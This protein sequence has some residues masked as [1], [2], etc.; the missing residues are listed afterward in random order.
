MTKKKPHRI[1]TV[2]NN[3]N[4]AES[5]EVAPATRPRTRIARDKTLPGMEHMRI[6]A[7]DDIC[8]SLAEIR[9]DKN[10][11]IADENG[12]KNT[13]HGLMRKFKKFTWRAHGVELAR[14][15]GEE[16]LRVRTTKQSATAKVEPADAGDADDQASIDNP[17][18]S[19]N[20]DD[21]AAEAEAAVRADEP[22]A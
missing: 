16:K 11:L 18:T 5:R 15:E 2:R 19:D 7:L 9:A 10:E 22:S 14:V 4:R 3:G 6:E 12:K 1:N 20:P 8:A 17:A 21:E 13:A